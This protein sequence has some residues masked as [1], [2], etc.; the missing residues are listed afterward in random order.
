[1]TT[2]DLPSDQVIAFDHL[3]GYGL[4]A[5]L[6]ALDP[7]HVRLRWTP[8]LDSRLQ[9]DGST[10][11]QAGEAVHTHASRHTRP[12]S[13]VMADGDNNGGRSGLFSP[14]VRPMDEHGV[15]TWYR[16]RSSVLDGLDRSADSALD[17]SMIGGLGEPSYWSFV[18][19]Q[20]R[21]DHGASRW[22]MKTRNRGEEFVA[23]RLRRLAETVANRTPL[24]VAQG[25]AGLTVDDEAGKNRQDSRTPTGLMP[26]SRTDNARAWCA[27]WGLSLTSVIH[28]SRGA[29]RSSGHRGR[30]S[31]GAFFLPLPTRFV[32][33]ARLRTILVSAA[34]DAVAGGTAG[35]VGSLEA[36]WSWLSSLGVDEVVSFPVFKSANVSAPERWAERGGPVRKE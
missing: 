36:H 28:T 3:A 23:H 32:S 25:L 6:D 7:G 8:D 12:D 35:A 27:L 13:W 2:L 20:V 5:I 9:I 24:E 14:R 34:L 11:E 33:V 21:P 1:M 4:A 19:D 29:S 30:L 10:W 16:S 17:Q 31:E 15:R 18:R 22:E 26:P